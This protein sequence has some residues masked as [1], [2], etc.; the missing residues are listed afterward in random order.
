MLAANT[1][2]LALIIIGPD[3]NGDDEIVVICHLFEYG[4]NAHL[5]TI[6]TRLAIGDDDQYVGKIKGNCARSRVE[7]LIN[8]RDKVE[9]LFYR[10][11]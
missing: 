7:M 10:L 9:C 11:D 2:Q 3:A 4:I 8:A 1:R 6:V 5:I